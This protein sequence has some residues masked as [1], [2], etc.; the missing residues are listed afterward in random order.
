MHSLK[1]P[2]STLEDLM[3]LPEEARAELIEGVI[4]MMAPALARHSAVCTR[5][6]AKMSSYFESKEKGPTDGDSWIIIS[7]AW[8]YYD[9]INSF[10]HDIAAYSQRDLPKFPEIGPI[11]VKPLWVCEILSPSNRLND[12]QRKKVI[13]EQHQVPFYWLVDPAKKTIQIFKLDLKTKHYEVLISESF[14]P[15]DDLVLDVNRI[16]AGM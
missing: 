16:F 6:A 4:Y 11:R 1:E 7:E 10:V 2:E 12:T 8:T 13:L 3:A 5:L 15:F 9:Q 14:P